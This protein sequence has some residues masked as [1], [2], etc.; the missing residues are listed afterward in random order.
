VL[1]DDE[2]MEADARVLQMEELRRSV[3]SYHYALLSLVLTSL[4]YQRPSG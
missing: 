2:D 4:P 3:L 1:S